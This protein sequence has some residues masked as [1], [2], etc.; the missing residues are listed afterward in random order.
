VKDLRIRG[1]DGAGDENPG[2]KNL[3]MEKQ[4]LGKPDQKTH[5]TAC[6]ME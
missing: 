1:M 6:P 3:S 5:P 4:G 2:R